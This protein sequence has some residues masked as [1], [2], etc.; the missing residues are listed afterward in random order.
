VLKI[1][2]GVIAFIIMLQVFERIG[3]PTMPIYFLAVFSV[4]VYFLAGGHRQQ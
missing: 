1:I 3:I 4:G 2:A